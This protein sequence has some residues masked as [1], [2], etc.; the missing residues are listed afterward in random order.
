MKTYAVDFETYYDKECSVRVYG[1]RGYFSHPKFDAYMVSVVSDTGYEF[2]GHPKDFDWTLLEDQR[3]LSHNA[4]FDESLYIY[5]VSKNW[6]PLV[7]Y[8]E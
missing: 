3:V 6:W 5:G 2:C 1:P 7:A 4:F 8:K